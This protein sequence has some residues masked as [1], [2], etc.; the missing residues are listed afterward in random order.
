MLR[1][2]GRG[3]PEKAGGHGDLYAHVRIMLPEGGDSELEALM[4][5]RK[6]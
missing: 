3:L 4:R 5:S 1:L 2:K 6:G